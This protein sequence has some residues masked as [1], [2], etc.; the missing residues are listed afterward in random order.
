MKLFH[1][2]F[3]GAVVALAVGL[4]A[5]PAT[6]PRQ[7]A[8]PA[9]GVFP[10]VAV[11]HDVTIRMRDGVRLLI[12]PWTHSGNA[13]TYAGDVDFDPDAAIK[14][15]ATLFHLRWFDH[16]LKGE[17]TGAER[18]A[19][20]RLFVMGGGDGHKNEQG[21]LTG[22]LLKP[23]AVEEFQI[24]P[25]STANAVTKGHRIRVDI[26]SSNFPMY[27]VNP[28]TGEPLGQ[29]RRLVSA[30]NTIYYDAAGPSHLALP[31]ASRAAVSPAGRQSSVG[32][33]RPSTR[34]AL[35]PSYRS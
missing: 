18:D 6:T 5:A 32:G 19:L 17:A 7:A 30:N 22:E 1:S 8:I 25:F 28:N 29:N 12:G 14:D 10:D 13:R 9:G 2:L 21:R 16:F 31:I 4:T 3:F 15:F 33:R 27:D 24:R 34:T 20:V 11:E 35:R 26:S 23:G